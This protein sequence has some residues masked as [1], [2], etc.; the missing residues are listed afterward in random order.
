[1]ANHFRHVREDE[2][3][4]EELAIDG[5]PGAYLRVAINIRAAK[6]QGS[7]TFYLPRFRVKALHHMLG[8]WLAETTDEDG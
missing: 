4:R 3:T 6:A 5:A 2:G 8:E 7:A 1:M